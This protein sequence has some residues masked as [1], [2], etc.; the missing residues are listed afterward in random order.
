MNVKSQ[1]L[2][3]QLEWATAAGLNPDQR[4]Y[5]NSYE[6][7]LFQTLSPQSKL[8]FDQGSGAE[9]RD[10]PNGPA[11]MRALHSSSALAVNF[12][13]AWVDADTKPLMEIFDLE[14][15]PINVRFEGKYPTG[16]PGNPPDLDVIFELQNGLVVGIESKFTEWLSPKP[17][18]NPPFKEKYFPAGIGVW[19]NVG[20]SETQRLAEELQSKELIFRH[21]D[22]P[23]LMKHA[24][25]I[26]TH[27]GSKFRLLY[28]YFDALG[29]EGDAH[30]N[31]IEIF[32]DRLK[33]EL[34]F[35]A[36]SY[37][38]L[39]GKLQ[40]SFGIPNEYLGYLRARYG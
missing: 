13:D 32:T 5:L 7:N 33:S 1:I 3:K 15:Q 30:R 12:F 28:V 17:A 35:R 4:G 22:A 38:E 26:A 19:E 31:E 24:L 25:G 2:N 10:R 39:I 16:L 36:F 21:L 11:K 20:L 6:S 8:A 40:G 9:L 34:G 29:Q 14:A 37:Q 23:Q 18:S 27:C